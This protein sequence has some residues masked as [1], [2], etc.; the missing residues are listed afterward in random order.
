MAIAAR[1]RPAT[2]AMAIA[3]RSR[4][5]TLAM[6]ITQAALV[7]IIRTARQQHTQPVV[8]GLGFYPLELRDREP[9]DLALVDLAQL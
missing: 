2:L 8:H 6:A 3:A 1:S 7:A 4:P 9:V 5:A